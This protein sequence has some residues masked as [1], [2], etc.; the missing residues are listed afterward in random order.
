M[1]AI[2]IDA[3]LSDDE[4]RARLYAGDIFILSPAAGSRELIALARE[5]LEEAFPSHNPR[6]IHEN[7]SPEEV[8]AILSKLKPAFIHLPKGK[9]LIPQI[10]REQGDRSR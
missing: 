7:L 4:R 10:M 6:T 1:G 9:T 8:V 5:M 3:E 2:F